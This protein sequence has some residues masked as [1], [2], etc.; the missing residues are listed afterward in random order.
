[1]FSWSSW[2]TLVPLLLGVAGIALFV[3][4]EQYFAKQPLVPMGIFGNLTANTV[5]WQSL[6]SGLNMWSI[7]YYMPLFFRGVKGYSVI[8]S[9]VSVLPTLLVVAPSAAIAGFAM[10]KI[11]SYRKVLWAGWVVAT[12]GAGVMIRLDP[13]MTIPQWIFTNSV[14]GIGIGLMLPVMRLAI[15]AS[16]SDKYVGHAA[17][18]VMTF[19]TL[20]MSL[21]NAIL[22]VIFQTVFQQKLE[23]ST[24]SGSI[25]GLS[26]NV[27]DVV[28]VIDQL[29]S[30][31]NDRLVLQQ[32]LAQSL[33]MIWVTMVAFNAV[34]L[35]SNFFIQ[36]LSL[37]RALNTEQGVDRGSGNTLESG[38]SMRTEDVGL[39]S[40]G[41]LTGSE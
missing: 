24:F 20:G 38:A 2:H 18:M 28:Q 4:W 40:D 30:D 22:S 19:R 5:Y 25:E 39:K 35:L 10:R 9:A 37:E 8:I 26:K 12:L 3:V 17:A 16:T 33:K 14:G 7:S 36:E 1:M 29:P 21:S 23:K 41:H 11:G 31:S 6:V 13:E 32:V 34:S 27:L 15:Q